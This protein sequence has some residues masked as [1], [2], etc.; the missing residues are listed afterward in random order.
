MTRCG[1]DMQPGHGGA[2]HAVAKLGNPLRDKSH[3][4]L[5]LRVGHARHRAQKGEA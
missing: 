2:Q 4:K 1:F 5:T 3:V